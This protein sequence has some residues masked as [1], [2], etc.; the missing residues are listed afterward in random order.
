[1]LSIVEQYDLPAGAEPPSIA[2][3]VSGEFAEANT[4]LTSELPP[5]DQK[6]SGPQQWVAWC[7][8]SFRGLASV[9]VSVG[10]ANQKWQTVGGYKQVQGRFD[11][12]SGTAFNPLVIDEVADPTQKGNPDQPEPI[13]SVQ[14]SAVAIVMTMPK[15]ARTR[16]F[17]LFLTDI[18]GKEMWP[19]GSVVPAKPGVSE[20]YYFQ[21]R[22]ADIGAIELQT[23]TY[24]WQDLG[25]VQLQPK[26]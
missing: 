3:S 6:M 18:N 26:S 22:R 5:A 11:L 14:R 1:M 10:V 7:S 21:G 2:F 9:P 17:R 8:K 13:H 16:A 20:E 4:Y 24:E 25:E 15:T 23:R 19:A 12:V